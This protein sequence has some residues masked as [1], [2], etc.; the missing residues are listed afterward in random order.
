MPHPASPSIGLSYARLAARS[1]RRVHTLAGDA[2]LP[3]LRPTLSTGP[4]DL[5][6]LARYSRVCGFRL[7][8]H[9]P[10]T[11]LH[12]LTFGLQ[13]Q[14]L[15]DPSFP[16]PALGLVHVDN[17][18]TVH[19]PVDVRESLV[20]SCWATDLHPHPKGLR[21]RLRG[22][23]RAEGALVWDGSSTYTARGVRLDEQ[24]APSQSDHVGAADVA[25]DDA[26]SAVGQAAVIQGPPAMPVVG[27]WRLPADLGR[28]YAAVS[29]DANPIHLHPLAARAFGFPGALVH[30]MWTHARSLASCAPLP[31]AYTATVQFRRPVLLPSTV[32]V[33]RAG[34]VVEVHGSGGARELL[35]RTSI[36][37]DE[38]TVSVE[39]P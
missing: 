32:T 26:A 19:R 37:P 2:V 15:A 4:S 18:M 14:V 13:M 34:G 10:A 6:R 17:Q 3:A 38:G 21:F 20:L 22:E 27:Q 33:H 28:R 29:G 1:V 12:V 7:T 39:A 24:L 8:G 23:A 9:L 31:D 35:A 5:E 30:G 36:E 16:L 25:A 11:Y